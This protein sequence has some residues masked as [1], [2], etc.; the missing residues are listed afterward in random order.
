M[1]SGL[2][3]LVLLGSACMADD[4]D[5]RPPPVLRDADCPFDEP[6]VRCAYLDV[7]AKR[8]DPASATLSLFV[9]I[10]AATDGPS[11]RAP[12]VPIAGG[13]G[14]TTGGHGWL[15][16]PLRAHYD[17]VLLDQRGTGL[18]EPALHC[19]ELEAPVVTSAGLSV[20]DPARTEALRDAAAA[21]RGRYEKRGVDLSAFN[22]EESAADIEDLRRALGVPQ[23]NLEGGSYGTRL[24]LEVMR[25]FSGSV[26]SAFLT[27]T[28][29]HSVDHFADVAHNADAAIRAVFEA[30]Q[31]DADCPE[32]D[33]QG[34]F[35][36]SMRWLDE[37]PNQVEDDLG[38]VY[39]ITSA[40][41]GAHLFDLLYHSDEIV[42]VPHVALSN[43]APPD[44]E[45]RSAGV[46]DR[47]QGLYLAVSCREDFPFAD[48]ER[49]E[50]APFYLRG[51]R[52]NLSPAVASCE[53]WDVPAAPSAFKEP[54]RSDIPTLLL[55]GRF[56]PITPPH[57]T[58]LAAQ[59]L[60]RGQ[61]V[62]LP[63]AG[64]D[65]QFHTPCVQR[66]FAAFL[67]DPSEPVDTSCVDDE[68]GPP[69]F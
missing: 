31:E 4:A 2:L 38:G 64:H 23:L 19:G 56:D 57:Y 6:G 36:A 17:I 1:R 32:P 43:G 12:I 40:D 48:R 39:N 49:A 37:H 10:G 33:M 53:G 51:Y 15:E 47:A 26:R 13:P 66:M 69:D 24:A 27:G 46:P 35:E 9:T 58:A 22:T 67:E 52:W 59:T 55:V 25:S 65:T 34:A 54:V 3:A 62:E 63:G 41:F 7:P 18:S 29:P 42:N 60:S 8:S 21:C 16:S 61:V 45:L 5:S 14:G 28:Y 44:D 20:D 30:C 50:E 11:D 68:L